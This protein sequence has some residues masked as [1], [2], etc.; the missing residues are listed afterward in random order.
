MCCPLYIVADLKIWR[1]EI[2]LICFFLFVVNYL[3]SPNPPWHTSIAKAGSQVAC[4]IGCHKVLAPGNLFGYVQPYGPTV[5]ITDCHTGSW[6]L[7]YDS[8]IPLFSTSR[9]FLMI[10]A[11]P[12]NNAFF[13]MFPQYY[14]NWPQ[15]SWLKWCDTS[16]WSNWILL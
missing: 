13:Y 11:P 8:S 10:S 12:W 2:I 5:Q 7:E 1:D 4:S 6:W 14:W 16:L 15:Q 9:N 3:P